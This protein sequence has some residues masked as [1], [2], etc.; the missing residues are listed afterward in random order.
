MNFPRVLYL[1]PG[2]FDKGGVSRYS[3][4]Q[5]RAMRESWGAANVCAVSLMGPDQDSLE[6]PFDVAW[7]GKST[8]LIDKMGF[9]LQAAKFSLTFRPT[10]I[11]V[12]HVHLAP[13][14]RFLRRLSGA[15][16][17][18]NVYGLE[19]WSGLSNSRRKAMQQV[20]HVIADCHATAD[21]VKTERM[22]PSQP[23][24]IW[25]CVDLDQF[26]PA[27]CPQEILSKYSIPLKKEY[28]VILTL[29]RLSH[30]ALHK[31]Y[32]RLL[33]VFSKLVT[34]YPQARLVFAGRGDYREPLMQ[35]V[36]QLKL[37]DTVSFTGG[38]D[39]KDL[40]NVY[41]SASVF[42]LVTD[43]GQ[44]RGEGIPMTPLE[45]M[46]CGAPILVG[47][48]DGSR[49]AVVDEKNGFVLDSL[50]LAMHESAFAK[51]L[52]DRELLCAKGDA[53]V[54]V[55]QNYF[56]YDRFKRDL[57]AVYSTQGFIKDN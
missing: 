33:E 32:D 28:F 52:D 2:C 9:S 34:R 37:N 8:R 4:Y 45:A 56:G 15:K 12:A 50:D 25:D 48:Q 6:D 46:A 43:K 11:H 53:A 26:F 47:N 1:T 16:V 14:A 5:I 44:D 41:R 57:N 19:I 31:G 18:L 22:H 3:R 36:A 27:E 35:K 7:N 38:V 51:L 49:E 10:V 20:D 13:L 29:G 42:S 54:R 24:V 21:Y 55:A 23:S 17:I 40:P 30:N 39:E